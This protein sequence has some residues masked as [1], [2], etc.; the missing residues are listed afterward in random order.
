[1]DESDSSYTISVS[2]SVSQS[3]AATKAQWN[4]LAK[5][6]LQNKDKNKSEKSSELSDDWSI[7]KLNQLTW[8]FNKGFSDYNFRSS[9][10][11]LF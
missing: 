3:D 5:K 9:S 7:I 1:M 6:Y 8:S 2:N 11:Q 4:Q 10:K